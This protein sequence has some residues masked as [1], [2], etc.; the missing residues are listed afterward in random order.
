MKKFTATVMLMLSIFVFVPETAF[1]AE[2]ESPS[3]RIGRQKGLSYLPLIIAQKQ[4]L[5]EKHAKVLGLDNLKIEW[6]YLASASALTESLLSENIHYVAGA[7]TVLNV[8][9]DKS[10]HDVKGVVNLGNFDY[11]LNTSNPAIQSVKDFTEKDRIAVSGVKLSVHAILLQM[12]SAEAFGA[13]QWDK[14]DKL[15]ISMSHP[16]AYTALT[17]GV[18]EITAHLTTPPFQELERDNPKVHKVFS[19]TDIVDGGLSVL[20]FAKSKVYAQHTIANKAI[21]AAIEE[22]DAFIKDHPEKAAEIYMEIEEKKS[23]LSLD[24]LTQFIASSTNEYTLLPRNILRFAQFQYKV[25]TLKTNPQSWRELFFDDAPNPK[26]A[27]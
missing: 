4:N 23:T 11:Q 27:Y 22:A 8:I 17:S 18:S 24:R 13:D 6:I 19:T 25:G 7:S 3:I 20:L 21:V 5:I 9:W 2:S 12:A 14:L 16:D 26:G 10:H 1:T 15:T